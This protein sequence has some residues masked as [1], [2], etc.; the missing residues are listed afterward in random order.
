MPVISMARTGAIKIGE[1]CSL[2]SVSEYTALGVSH[3]VILRTLDPAAS[4]HVGAHTGISGAT[5]CAAKGIRIG[6]YVS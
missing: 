6:A 2:C 3:P 5:I 1:R 4:I